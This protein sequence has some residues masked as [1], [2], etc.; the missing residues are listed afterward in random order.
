MN[1]WIATNKPNTVLGRLLVD[2]SDPDSDLCS[3][4]LKILSHMAY[5]G[6]DSRTG[7]NK[8][9]LNTIGSKNFWNINSLSALIIIGY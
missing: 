8:Q 6:R 4:S 7:W 2:L 9:F 5:L 3:V 1:E